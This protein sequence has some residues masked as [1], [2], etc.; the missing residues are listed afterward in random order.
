ML[1]TQYVV[2]QRGGQWKVKFEGKHYGP[3][4]TQR[5]AIRA[6]IDQAYKAGNQAAHAPRVLVESTFNSKLQTEWT[7]GE[8]PYPPRL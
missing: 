8:D 1:R 7:Y 4:N 5:E 2:L 6:A 3:F